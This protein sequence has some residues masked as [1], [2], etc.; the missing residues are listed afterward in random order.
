M[1]RDGSERAPG[2]A[3]ARS[4]L[5]RGSERAGRACARITRS[6]GSPALF[7]IILSAAVAGLFFTLGVVAE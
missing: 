4:G 5:R 6:L 3:R 1:K 2:A 7:A